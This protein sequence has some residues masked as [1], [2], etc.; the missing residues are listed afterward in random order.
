MNL[1][2]LNLALWVLYESITVSVQDRQGHGRGQFL[3]KDDSN[4]SIL[5]MFFFLRCNVTTAKSF[6]RDC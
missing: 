5:N 3:V 1:L 6:I 4:K 2:L